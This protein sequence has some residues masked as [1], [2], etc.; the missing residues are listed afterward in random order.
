[1]PSTTLLPLTH[2]GFHCKKL[3]TA[4][5]N[6]FSMNLA[7]EV[8][9]GVKNCSHAHSVLNQNTPSRVA[10]NPPCQASASQFSKPGSG[11]EKGMS[12]RQPGKTSKDA[13]SQE[14]LMTATGVKLGNEICIVGIWMQFTSML[15]YTV[16]LQNL[17]KTNHWNIKSHDEIIKWQSF[18][19]Q[20]F[21]RI[22]KSSQYQ[23]HR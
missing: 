19:P 1:M 10:T 12:V 14:F 22:L 5:S 3:L 9:L 18:P 11:F 7:E 16:T 23:S 20:V 4:C 13:P 15:I 21:R 6:A 8:T 2:T 17:Q